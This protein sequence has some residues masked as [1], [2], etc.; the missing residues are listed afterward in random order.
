MF[1][2]EIKLSKVKVNS[3]ELIEYRLI[4]CDHGTRNASFKCP[5]KWRDSINRN[6]YFAKIIRGTRKFILVKKN[7]GLVAL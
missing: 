2:L 5:Q 1:P 7:W 4:L 3:K 6:N